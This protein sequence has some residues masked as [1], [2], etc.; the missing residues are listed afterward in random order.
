MV[1]HFVGD[2]IDNGVE[3]VVVADQP[4]QVE[5]GGWLD[6]C[7]RSGESRSDCQVDVERRLLPGADIDVECN[8]VAVGIRLF[9]TVDRVGVACID[10]AE[11]I[12]EVDLREASEFGE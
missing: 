2:L 9:L 4:G 12:A 5:R 7:H 3:P 11:M 1:A 6:R 8:A 10:E